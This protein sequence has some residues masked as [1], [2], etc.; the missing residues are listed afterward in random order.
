MSIEGMDGLV[1]VSSTLRV[2]VTTPET[3]TIDSFRLVGRTSTGGRVSRGKDPV[4][5]PLPLTVSDLS[6][7]LARPYS[8]P[9]QSSRESKTHWR[10]PGCDMRSQCQFYK[11]LVLPYPWPVNLTSSRNNDLQNRRGPDSKIHDLPS[12]YPSWTP[13]LAPHPHPSGTPRVS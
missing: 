12:R 10:D 11:S 3:S 9:E 1:T 13:F 7:V 8:R 5:G 2:S 6:P 4:P